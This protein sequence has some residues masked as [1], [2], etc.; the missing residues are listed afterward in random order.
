MNTQFHF[1]SSV[2]LTLVHSVWQLALIALLAATSFSLLPKTIANAAWRHSLGMVWLSSMLVAPVITFSFYWLQPSYSMDS[3]QGV[4]PMFGALMNQAI[5]PMER[6]PKP[7]MDWAMVFASQIWLI[8][9]IVMLMRQ[10]GGWRLL[11]RI[12]AE[13]FKALP[14]EWQQRVEY[15]RLTMRIQRTVIVRLADGAASP[16]TA[17][18]IRPII[19][20]PLTLLTHLP[21]EQIEALLAHELAHIR[22]LDWCWNAMQCV[23]EALLFYHP[24]MWWLSG[25]I[26]QEREHACDDFAVAVSGDA[27]ALA[28]A[29]TAVQRQR[30]PLISPL[31]STSLR[32]GLS[33][34][35]NGG[36]LMKRIVHLLSGTPSKKNWLV[37]SALVMLLCSGTLVAMQVEAPQRL[38]TNLTTEISSTGE[39]T[40]GNYREYTANYLFDKQRYYR[41]SMDQQG[42]VDEVYKENGE[43]KPMTAQART[44]LDN[45]TKMAATN[46][47][48]EQPESAQALASSTL[49]PPPPLPPLPPSPPLPPMPPEPLASL[50][51]SD[52]T[53]FQALI[54]SIQADAQLIAITGS[55]VIAVRS[56]FHGSVHIWD[57]L[58]FRIWGID[59]ADGGKAK[60]KMVF[61]G[62]KARAMVDYSGKTVNGKWTTQSMEIS[63]ITK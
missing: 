20:L 22:R 41:I 2:A 12:E 17:F 10:V 30:Q 47:A 46:V 57:A 42:R 61:A 39:L 48:P 50:S 56:S 5:V 34:R 62:P 60:F 51:A 13:P 55:P 21:P 25:R 9:V 36:Y 16:F 52:S 6:S 59:D 14:P 38:L 26:R 15:L 27:I 8:G 7:W 45:V 54:R 35:A 32:A 58:D 23:I 11:R 53:E 24:A 63:P 43:N 3:S 49:P 31:N 28:E 44:W 18:A 19:W 4:L 1:A 40:P 29:L 37:P 33:L